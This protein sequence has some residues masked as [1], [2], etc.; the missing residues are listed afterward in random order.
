MLDCHECGELLFRYEGERLR[1]KFLN[2]LFPC[3]SEFAWKQVAQ[4]GCV[5]CCNSI[6]NNIAVV[7]RLITESS[8]TTFVFCIGAQK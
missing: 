7:S 2:A 5:S 6:F 3:A 4:A 1:S 8:R